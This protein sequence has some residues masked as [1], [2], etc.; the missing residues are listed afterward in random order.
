[1]TGFSKKLDYL[2][3]LAHA[4]DKMILDR[5]HNNKPQFTMLSIDWS[6]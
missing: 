5:L 4:Y 2:Y 1:M 6:L 3:E